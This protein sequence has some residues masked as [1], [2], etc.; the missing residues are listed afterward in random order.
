MSL[1]LSRLQTFLIPVVNF[2]GGNTFSGYVLIDRNKKVTIFVMAAEMLCLQA[3][4]NCID[5][6]M[7]FLLFKSGTR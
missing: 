4:P 7:K 6:C 3:G 5:S 2:L 1:G